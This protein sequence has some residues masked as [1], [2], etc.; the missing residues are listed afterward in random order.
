MRLSKLQKYILEKCYNDKSYL[1]SDFY[2][3]YVK[4][5]RKKLVQD[6]IHQSLD[7]L[8][9]K[10]LLTA[11]GKKT[12]KKWFIQKVKLTELGRKI[13]LVIIKNK[14]RRLPIK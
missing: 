13:A 10:D 2:D 14:Q 11:Q 6:I 3:F 9:A 12:S 5:K 7:S 1:P 8:V 4:N